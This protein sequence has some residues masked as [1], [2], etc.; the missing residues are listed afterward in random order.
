MPT[1]EDSIR[2]ETSISDAHIELTELDADILM[3]IQHRNR[4][5]KALGE[6]PVNL[7]QHIHRDA[8]VQEVL[9]HHRQRGDKPQMTYVQCDFWWERVA[10]QSGIKV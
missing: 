3:L 10:R 4:L 8:Q 2:A 7:R 5:A 1:Y 6:R 9:Q